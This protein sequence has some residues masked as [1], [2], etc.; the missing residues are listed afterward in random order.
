MGDVH[1]RRGHIRHIAQL[2]PRAFLCFRTDALRTW[3]QKKYNRLA[4]SQL[5]EDGVNRQRRSEKAG[6][7]SIMAAARTYTSLI[8]KKILGGV[9]RFSEVHRQISTSIRASAA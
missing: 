9:H 2:L 8:T 1:V 6:K 7:N 5:V 4:A 3:I